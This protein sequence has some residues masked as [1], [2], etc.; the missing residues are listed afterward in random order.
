MF[1]EATECTGS[2]IVLWKTANTFSRSAPLPPISRLE[3]HSQT[4]RCARLRKTVRLCFA[5]MIPRYNLACTTLKPLAEQMDLEK[6]YDIYD[7]SDMDLQEA[8]IGYSESEFEDLDA[9]R[10]LKIH[11]ARFHTIR[12]IFLCWLLALDAHGGK[13]DLTRW[14]TA[15]DEIHAVGII[16]GDAEAQLRRILVEEESK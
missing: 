15:M 1:L 2:L 6:Y 8:M 11:G 3:D 7:V 5:D 14:G 16:T 12:K 9:L 4:R 13:S 10:V